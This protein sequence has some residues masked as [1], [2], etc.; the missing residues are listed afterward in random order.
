ME[1]EWVPLSCGLW[2]LTHTLM[3]PP[4]P[5]SKEQHTF[6]MVNYFLKRKEHIKVGRNIE[7]GQ[8]GARSDGEYYLF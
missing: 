8:G 2:L 4:I 7:V 5:M 3:D 6:G 1:G